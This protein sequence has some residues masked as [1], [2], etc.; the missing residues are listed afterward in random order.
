MNLETYYSFSNSGSSNNKLKYSLDGGVTWH[1]I[2]IPEGSYE[3]DYLNQAIYQQMRQN[4][5]Y[6]ELHNQSFIK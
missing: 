2:L 1:T 6:D 3:L 4:D 5:Y